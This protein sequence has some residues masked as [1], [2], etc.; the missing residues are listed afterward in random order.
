MHERFRHSLWSAGNGFFSTF[1]VM[2]KSNAVVNN[3]LKVLAVLALNLAVSGCHSP[4]VTSPTPGVVGAWE[5]I[6][7]GKT[8]RHLVRLLFNTDGTGRY[9]DVSHHGAHK[10]TPA[11]DTVFTRP[12]YWKDDGENHLVIRYDQGS[13][14]KQSIQWLMSSDGKMLT[15]IHS[16]DQADVY[17]RQDPKARTLAALPGMPRSSVAGENALTRPRADAESKLEALLESQ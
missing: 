8:D 12:L 3:C 10:K 11:V 1:T 17:Y 6:R 2:E 16:N 5:S 9:Q 7:S 15:L 4:T 14:A 13:A